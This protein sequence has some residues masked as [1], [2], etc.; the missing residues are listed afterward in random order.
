MGWCPTG[1]VLPLD[2]K[3]PLYSWLAT[4][5]WCQNKNALWGRCFTLTSFAPRLLLL[6]WLKQNLSLLLDQFRLA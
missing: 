1:S 5:R 3:V 2:E 6:A 4:L